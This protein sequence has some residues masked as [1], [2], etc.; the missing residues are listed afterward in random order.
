MPMTIK[1]PS[2]PENMQAALSEYPLINYTS[3][4]GWGLS[5]PEGELFTKY[6]DFFEF[7][8]NVTRKITTTSGEVDLTSEYVKE[9]FDQLE[10]LIDWNNELTTTDEDVTYQDFIQKGQS[11]VDLSFEQSIRTGLH[12]DE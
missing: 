4:W 8:P 5:Y 3:E 11:I 1:N 12:V 10:G 2:E 6:Y 9:Q 7:K